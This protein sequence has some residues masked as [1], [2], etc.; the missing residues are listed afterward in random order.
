M[1]MQ[2]GHYKVLHGLIVDDRPAF[3][4]LIEVLLLTV[5]RRR[6]G[7]DRLKRLRYVEQPRDVTATR[8]LG[9][10]RWPVSLRGITT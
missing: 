1:F 3:L 10:C 6:Q 4:Q 9:W 7:F 2:G 8:R 5:D